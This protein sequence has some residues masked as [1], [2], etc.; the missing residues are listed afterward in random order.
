MLLCTTLIEFRVTSIPSIGLSPNFHVQLPT[1]L[2]TSDRRIEFRQADRI[3]SPLSRSLESKQAAQRRCSRRPHFITRLIYHWVDP[4][5]L[6][7]ATSPLTWTRQG[8]SSLA[9]ISD[10]YRPLCRYDLPMHLFHSS[11]AALFVGKR[12]YPLCLHRLNSCRGPNTSMQVS[13]SQP[14]LKFDGAHCNF[15]TLSICSSSHV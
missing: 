5:W 15:H 11:K 6:Q 8:S 9:F 2:P 14:Q 3:R 7:V 10:R 13:G 1:A 4:R 12:P